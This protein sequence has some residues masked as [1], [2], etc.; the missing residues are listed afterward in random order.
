VLPTQLRV[1]CRI[2]DEL[3]EW[4]VLAR[5][6]TTGAGKVVNARVR[7]TESDAAMIRVWGA[8]E[9]VAVQRTTS[10]EERKR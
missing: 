5:P 2:V 3:G 4:Q 9:Q 7:R 1:G 10:S 8:H 6:Y